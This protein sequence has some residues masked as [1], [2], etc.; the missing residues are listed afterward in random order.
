[1]KVSGEYSIPV[2]RERVWQALSDI[3]LLEVCIPGCFELDRVSSDE[4]EARIDTTVGPLQGTFVIRFTLTELSAPRSCSVRGEGTCDAAGCGTV[5]AD[6]QLQSGDSDTQ[7]S[8][9]L[10]LDV[11]GPLAELEPQLVADTATTM[12]DEFFG[13]FA[14]QLDPTTQRFEIEEEEGHEVANIA[15]LIASTGRAVVIAVAL[16]A[17]VLVAG[18]ALGARPV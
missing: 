3:E 1:V 15:M 18:F 17:V 4:F 14:R 16:L 2:G 9:E 6:L 7:V 12:A 8:Y 10:N 5:S 13:Q 11:G